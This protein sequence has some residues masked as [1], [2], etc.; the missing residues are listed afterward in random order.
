MMRRRVARIEL[1]RSCELALHAGCLTHKFI[2]EASR[3]CL[4][5]DL[6]TS[7]SGLLCRFYEEEVGSN[8]VSERVIA[9][10]NIRLAGAAA[11]AKSAEIEG[12]YTAAESG[13]HEFGLLS[14]GQA[15]LYVN[16]QGID[17]RSAARAPLRLV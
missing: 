1:H 17:R 2:P 13:D 5:P 8:L 3:G 10:S 6:E 7:A 9:A 11:E 4:S 12:F 15:R 14:T 16:D